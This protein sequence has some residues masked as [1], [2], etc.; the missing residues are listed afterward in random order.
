MSNNDRM[1][2]YNASIKPNYYL[3]GVSMCQIWIS[4]SSVK[5]VMWVP[6]ENLCGKWQEPVLT[7]LSDDEV[8]RNGQL[9][10]HFP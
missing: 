1:L 9:F 10:I 8:R 3:N 5:S 7:L 4:G 6:R 2:K